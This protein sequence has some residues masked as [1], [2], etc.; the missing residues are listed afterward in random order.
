MKK[1]LCIISIV[2][3]I[4]C[5]DSDDS[6][7]ELSPQILFTKTFGGNLNES[8]QSICTT[9]DGGYIVL[10]YTQSMDGDITDKNTTVFDFYLLKFASNDELQWTKTLGGSANDKG[11]KIIQTLDNNFTVAGFTSSSDGDISENFGSNDIW[12]AKLDN[13]GNVLWEKSHGF[14]G[15]DQGF[16]LIQTSNGGYFIGGVLDVSASNGEGNDRSAS[17]HAGGDYWGIQ[18]DSDGEKIWRRYFGGSFTDTTY[19]VIE[20]DD[21]GFLLIGSSD[22]EDVDISGNKGEYDFWIVRLNNDGE[23]LWEKSYGGAQIDEARSAIK[24]SDGNY[25]ILGDSRSTDQDVSN[26]NGAADFWLIKISDNGDM[27]WEKSYG[28]SSFDAGR[29]VSASS[30]NGFILVGS[31]RSLDGNL[32]ENKGQN[33]MWLVKIDQIGNLQWQ[34]SVGGSAIDIAY[35]AVEIDSE[36]ILIAGETNSTDG[37]ILE[38][39]GFTDVIIAKIKLE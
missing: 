31:S 19:D 24:T 2:L 14:E 32:T 10:G 26:S 4:G 35:S 20:T 39:K 25:V 12:V 33:D 13:S 6:P 34:K 27:I 17:R 23:L 9:S 22:S 36:T 38:N 37:D 15:N 28:G 3:F 29:H 21:N 1:V 30:D 5:S 11:Y 18:L 16:S 7:K 8:A